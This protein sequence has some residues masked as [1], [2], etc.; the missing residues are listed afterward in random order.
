M[1]IAISAASFAQ[2]AK[3]QSASNYLKYNEL[4]KAKTAIDQASVHAK[5]SGKAKTWFTLGKIYYAIAVDTTAEFASL[6]DGALIK[7]KDA[8]EKVIANPDPKITMQEVYTY[9]YVRVY[10]KMYDEAVGYY[11]AKDYKN[12]SIYFAYCGEIKAVNEELDTTAYYY[13]ANMAAADEDH[14]NAIKYFNKLKGSGFEDGVVYNKLASQYKA[15]GDTT[16]AFE[17]ITEGRG[18]YP[19]N[20]SLLIAEFNMYVEIGENQKAID[21]I[22]KAIAANPEKEA[23]YYVRG[24]LKETNEDL[25]GAIVDYKKTIELDPDHLDANHDLGALYVNSG[26]KL[27][28]EINAIPANDLKAY[29][30]K[31]KEL[32]AVYVTALPY[33]EKAYELDPS[34]SEVQGILKQIYLKTG[35]MDKYKEIQSVIDAAK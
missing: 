26:R 35:N 7:S 2:N 31:K 15:S 11:N 13:A 3:V 18:L 10:N 24:K 30:A 27:V 34:D 5:T 16:K 32:D 29:D 23:Y 12:A 33:L 19:D 8:F 4:G 1:A 22:D 25:E 20:Q 9:L 6:R 17:M 28:D 21:N 14:E